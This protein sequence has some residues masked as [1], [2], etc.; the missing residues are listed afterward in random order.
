MTSEMVLEHVTIAERTRAEGTD[1]GLDSLVEARHVSVQVI[2]TAESLPTL[3]HLAAVP[4]II[5]APVH[6]C[7]LRQVT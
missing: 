5:S 7:D 4:H 6:L 2:R 3:C 1:E